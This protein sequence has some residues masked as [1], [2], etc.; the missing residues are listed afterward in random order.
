MLGANRQQ[1]NRLQERIKTS[2]EHWRSVRNWQIPFLQNG[3][4]K[5]RKRFGKF[6]AHQK[7]VWQ[8]IS[9]FGQGKME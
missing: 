1:T 9:D 8:D 2:C 3:M 4:A 5:S 7:K 6:K